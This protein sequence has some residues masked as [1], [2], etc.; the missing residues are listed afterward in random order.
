M[1]VEGVAA[2]V[3]I[4]N[5]EECVLVIIACL[6]KGSLAPGVS[7]LGFLLNVDSMPQ[8][9]LE[10]YNTPVVFKNH[11]GVLDVLQLEAQSPNV[12]LIGMFVVAVCYNAAAIVASSNELNLFKLL[13]LDLGRS[14]LAKFVV[15]SKV[16][17]L[18]FIVA[19][20]VVVS[21]NLLRLL[22]AFIS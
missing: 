5:L 3:A 2:A 18:P 10:V 4:L 13:L 9:K 21:P 19:L 17:D 8:S 16:Y 11:L 15:A 6:P 1:S 7:L 20:Q 14:L 12:N 22:R